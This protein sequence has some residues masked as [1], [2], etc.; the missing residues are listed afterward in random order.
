MQRIPQIQ[1][2][3]HHCNE[4]EMGV[5]GQ[6]IEATFSNVEKTKL[7]YN[8]RRNLIMMDGFVIYR[9]R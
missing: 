5:K 4:A 3:E 9:G 6:D 7:D 1:E 2:A 8:Q